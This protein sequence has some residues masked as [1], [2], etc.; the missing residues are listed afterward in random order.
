MI[1][2]NENH[3]FGNY[4]KQLLKS[5]NLPHYNNGRWANDI[6]N[7]VFNKKIPN[8]T[9]NF[10][11]NSNNYDAYTHEYLGEYLRFY[12]DYTKVN[13]MPLYNCFSNNLCAKLSYKI[14]EDPKTKLK[15]LASFNTN[16]KNY[17]IY[18]FPIK[19]DSDYT[20][21]ID[22]ASNVEL[23]C[24]IYSKY[25]INDINIS[26]PANTGVP[27]NTEITPPNYL[28]KSTDTAASVDI[29]TLDLPKLTYE[30]HN[31]M[32]FHQPIIYNRLQTSNIQNDTI[33]KILK[34]YEDNLKL[35]IK[36]DINSETSITVLE[37][38]YLNYN[39]TSIENIYEEGTNKVIAFKKIQNK[40]IFNFDKLDKLE[41]IDLP[42][43]TNLDLLKFNTGTS[44]PFADRLI[45]YLTDNA[46]TS[47]DELKDNIKRVQTVMEDNQIEFIYDGIWE[48]KIKYYI[49]D[50]MQKDENNMFKAN[51]DILGY[52]DKD[53]EYLYSSKKT[54]TTIAL[55]DIYPTM[56]LSSKQG[57]K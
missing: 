12:R 2:F 45:E 55:V 24:G 52:I 1:T 30:K 4:I 3:I 7:Y 17:K 40:T 43:I 14:Y 36:M 57:G 54:N 50:N 34:K 6:P 16:D 53:S 10:K 23:C 27:A 51:H 31:F 56:Y 48:D 15:P 25:Q 46:I 33:I 11:I 20:I 49:Y 26:V 21:A 18:Y 39:D 9:K 19:L 5:F 41:T 8:V 29:Y 35:F 13:L 42:F 22:S 37:G 47:Q 44:Y 32:N 38:N 28:I